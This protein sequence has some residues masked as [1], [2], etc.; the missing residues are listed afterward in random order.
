MPYAHARA[1]LHLERRAARAAAQLRHAAHVP[2]KGDFANTK[3]QADSTSNDDSRGVGRLL[4]EKVADGLRPSCAS[5]P[6]AMQQVLTRAWHA[7]PIKRCT[8]AEVHV[9]IRDMAESRNVAG[10]TAAAKEAEQQE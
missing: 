6:F 5:L 10:A 8:A 2:K 1:Q 7:D 4:F 3:I 9:C